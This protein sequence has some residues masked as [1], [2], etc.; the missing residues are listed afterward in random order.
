M[1]ADVGGQIYVNVADKGD[2][3]LALL[4]QFFHFHRSCLRFAFTI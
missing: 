1:P 4:W 3:S 2:I